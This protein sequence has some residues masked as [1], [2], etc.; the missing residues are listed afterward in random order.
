M[1]VTLKQLRS[2]IAVAEELNFTRAAGRLHVSQPALSV[3]IANLERDIGV[4]LLRRT[5]RSVALTEAGRGLYEDS[6]R[7]LADLERASARAR[8]AHEAVGATVRIAYTASVAYEALPRILDELERAEPGLEVV[9]T[10]T[11]SVQAI[12]SVT[13]GE[14]DVALVREYADRE[15][16][17]SELVRREP[18]EVV[19]STRHVLAGRA[20][21]T[22]DD[23]R[24]QT[25]VVVP[26]ALAPGFHGVVARLCERRG[27]RPVQV[28]LLSPDNREPLLAHLAR[29]EDRLFV[30]PASMAGLGWDGIRHLPLVDGD[31]RM[32]LSAVWAEGTRSAATGR[33]VDAV[34]R[35]AAREGWTTR[36]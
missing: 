21:L 9:A 19:L 26:E 1:D 16:L 29:H 14:A 25:V 8:R 33:V 36:P 24:G 30:G 27:F 22:V 17:R 10:Q 5:S 15:G 20:H 7:L 3:Q 28:E 13:L 6:R 2:F 18:L 11:W 34:R 35:V 32:G 12:E 31:A 23:L 4:E